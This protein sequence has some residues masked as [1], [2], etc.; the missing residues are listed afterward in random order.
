ML[1][2]A[3]CVWYFDRL[4][5]RVLYV[6]FSVG[7]CLNVVVAAAPGAGVVDMYCLFV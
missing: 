7:C 5:L 1:I 6:H 4:V 3:S 2:S